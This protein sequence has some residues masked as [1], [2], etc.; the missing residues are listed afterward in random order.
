M[1]RLL[2]PLLIV[3]FAVWPS[4]AMDPNSPSLPSRDAAVVVP[5]LK[6]YRSYWGPTALTKILG[7]PEAATLVKDYHDSLYNLD[8]GTIVHVRGSS[9]KVYSI[10]LESS[11]AAKIQVLYALNKKWRRP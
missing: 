8:D 7:K 4:F 1:A 6:G 10:F 5:L 2:I 11:G 3:L 9:T